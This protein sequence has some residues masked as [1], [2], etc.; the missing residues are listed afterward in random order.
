MLVLNYFL[1]NCQNMGMCIHVL[2]LKGVASKAVKG[3]LT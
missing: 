3:R 1:G 2:R